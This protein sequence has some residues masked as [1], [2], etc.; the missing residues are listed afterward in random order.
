[1]SPEKMEDLR[2]RIALVKGDLRGA[3]GRHT[4][5]FSLLREIGWV[6]TSSKQVIQLL[7][8]LWNDAEEILDAAGRWHDPEERNS[9]V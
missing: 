1:M 7:C 3:G 5:R 9:D 2:I 8:E 6:T 4:L